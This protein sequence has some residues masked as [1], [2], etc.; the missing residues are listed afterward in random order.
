MLRP[1][2]KGSD[3]GRLQNPPLGPPATHPSKDLS[4]SAWPLGSRGPQ[5]SRQELQSPFVCPRQSGL[6]SKPVRRSP[7][8]L[9]FHPAFLRLNLVGS[10][11]GC[12]VHGRKPQG[13]VPEPILI[14]TSG[15][16]ISG[17]REWHAAVS[18]ARSALECTE[19]QLND[20]EALQ[21][22]LILQQSRGA[23][24]T[25]TRIQLA[26]QEESLFQS[27]ALANQVAGGKYK[28]LAN[29]PEAKHIDVRQEIA[30]LAGVGARNISK[31]KTILQKAHPRLIEGCQ[32]GTLRINR[33]LQL[34]RLPKAEQVEQLSHYLMERSS[35]KTTRQSISTLR[36]EKIGPQVGVLLR[37]L[38]QREA[39]EPGSVVMRPGTRKQTVILI[40]RD[41]WGD[42]APLMGMDTT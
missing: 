35:G 6:Q 21:L 8:E 4:S 32:N 28:G 42:F 37:A 30:S 2:P 36:M 34:C 9:R 22:I 11:I 27:K 5:G 18:E 29:L 39:R 13:S 3:T 17:F 10:V 15:I 14:T 38:Q 1:E 24:N 33:A 16:I 12:E 7:H 20:D 23:W 25:F 19:Y 26:L 31:V 41:C 40:G